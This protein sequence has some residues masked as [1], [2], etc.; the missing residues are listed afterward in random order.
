VELPAWLTPLYDAAQMREVDRWAIEERG[1]PSLELMESAGAALAEVAREL[2]AREVARGSDGAVAIVCGK[3]NNGGDGFVCARHLAEAKVPVEVLLLHRPDEVSGD[4]RVNLERLED[5]FEQ[6]EGSDL[7]SKLSGASVVVD[8]VLGTGFEGTARDPAA[9]AIAAINAAGL[10]V[11]ACDVPS[12]LDASTGRI[13]GEATRCEATVTFHA[14]KVGHRVNPGRDA[15]GHL[16][17]API[18]IPEGAPVEAAAGEIAAAVLAG[19]PHRNGA[20]SK[21]TSG[22]VVLAGGSRGLTGAMAMAASASIRAGAGYATALVP[23][24]LEPI[25]EAKLTEVMTRGLAEHGEGAGFASGAANSILD[26][27]E[28]AGAFVLGPGLGRTDETLELAREVAGRIE[29]PLVLDADGLYA[30]RERPHRLARRAGPTVITPHA[31]EAA[32][33]L[34]VASD[35]VNAGRLEAARELA[36]RSGAVVVLKGADTIVAETAGGV[37]AVN[38]VE[39][40]GLATAGTGDVLSG[41]IAALLARGLEPLHAACAAVFAHARAGRAAAERVGADHVI[42]TDVI[43]AIPEGFTDE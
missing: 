25:L 17:V 33:L 12:G 43:E 27:A 6:V 18:G 34:G 37:V 3:G 5:R 32:R 14:P 4:A 22:R 10:P 38:S 24:S 39:S 20:S 35:E 13:E 26:A 7:G 8:A 36:N 23:H 21:F 42:A 16:T 40:P 11:V 31:G 15:C 1:V 2:H 19:L 29:A 30:F 41:M 28:G 9:A